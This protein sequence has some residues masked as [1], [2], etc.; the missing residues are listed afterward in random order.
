MRI[1]PSYGIYNE[2]NVIASGYHSNAASLRA[3]RSFH[4]IGPSLSWNASVPLMDDPQNSE[5]TFDWGLN[6][7]IL[8][9]RQRAKVQHQATG[10]YRPTVKDPDRDV[11]VT[12]QPPP[13]D[14][15]RTNTVTVPNVGG[16]AG[17]SW[18][19]QNFKVS[20][21]YRADL[22]FGA[23]DGGIDARKN[24]NVG[25]YGPFATISIGFP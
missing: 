4:G 13:I 1:W 12:Y 14:V 18:R 21:G 20:A 15:T 7:A 23:M 8:F 16:F 10:Q 11:T 9:G 6:A 5:L 2:K 17:A 19:I 24:E 22:F 3:A 25:F